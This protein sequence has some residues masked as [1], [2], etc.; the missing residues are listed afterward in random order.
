[1]GSLP[2]PDWIIVTFEG[3][4][5]GVSPLSWG[6]RHSWNIVSRTGEALCVGGPFKLAPGTTVDEITSVVRFAISRHEVLRTLLHRG[7]NGTMYQ[8]VHRS[9][10]V[11]IEVIDAGDLDP[12]LIVGTVYEFYCNMNFDYSLEWPVK[13]GVVH[14]NGELSH[15]VVAYG[16]MAV[17]GAGLHA[18]VRDLATRDQVPAPPVRGLTPREQA[19]RQQQPAAQ[20]QNENALRAWKAMLQRVPAS[21]FRPSPDP[22]Q[23]RYW[24]VRFTS[25]AMYRA[26]ALVAQRD[27]VST[28]PVMVATFAV[29][30]AELAGVDTAGFQVMVS[31]RFRP[32]FADSVSPTSQPSL[33]LIDVAG[34]SFDEIVRQAD[35]LAV[36]MHLCAY[37]DPLA[38]DDLIAEVSRERGEELDLSCFFN[39]RRFEAP[40]QADEV[41]S[42][43]DVLAVTSESQLTWG[44]QMDR[45]NEKLFV[46]VNDVQG[47]IELFACADTHYVSPA[48]L[49]TLLRRMEAILVEQA[50]APGRDHVMAGS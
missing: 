31:N 13:F 22:R 40:R 37:Y 1:M 44:V 46:H 6:Q 19:Q 50:C 10:Q 9:G 2:D 26:I 39:D 25:P 4:S 33:C 11:A 32:G 30:V 45:F 24:E 16:H 47:S 23:P 49:E 38:L 15:L 35:S 12:D 21:M 43:D 42:V 3:D 41:F 17:D 48:Q 27:R 18:L 36:R 5:S 7:P 20:R 34:L 29:A 28:S 14:R 8:E